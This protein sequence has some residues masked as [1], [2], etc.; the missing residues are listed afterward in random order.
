MLPILAQEQRSLRSKR[1]DGAAA[2]SSAGGEMAALEQLPIGSAKER[3]HFIV[4]GI[5][6]HNKDGML[7][8]IFAIL[9]IATPRRGNSDG[10]RAQE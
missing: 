10:E 7:A 9:S 8:A 3:Q 6:G 5:V 1:V 4:I 2:A